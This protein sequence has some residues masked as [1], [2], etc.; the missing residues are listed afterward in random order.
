MLMNFRTI[1]STSVVLVLTIV[2]LDYLRVVEQLYAII[3]NGVQAQKR[4]LL[5]NSEGVV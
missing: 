5:W 4:T 3:V 1:T 2:L